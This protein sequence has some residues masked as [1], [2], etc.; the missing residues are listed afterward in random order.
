MKKLFLI[1]IFIISIISFALFYKFYR[2]NDLYLP[3]FKPVTIAIENKD[4]YK[5]IILRAGKDYY[6]FQ[7]NKYVL[8]QK[9]TTKV[10]GVD[11]YIKKGYEN[12]IKNIAIYNGIN[13]DF[14]GKI[15]E[16]E[17]TKTTICDGKN[18]EDYYIFHKKI[19]NVSSK[20]NTIC[21]FLISFISGNKIFIVPYL[22]LFIFLIF[23]KNEIFQFLSKKYTV[24]LIFI[25]AFILRLNFTTTA[26]IGDECFSISISDSTK[27]FSYLFTDAGNPPVY[28][29]LLRLL[30]TFSSNTL[31]YKLFGVLI[32]IGS[33]GAIY[34]VLKKNFNSKTANLG[35]FL[36]TINLVSI[37]FSQELRSYGLQMALTPIAVYL[38]FELLRKGKLKY[39]IYYTL[40]AII[41]INLHYFEAL[42]LFSNFFFGII[43][44]AIKNKKKDILKFLLIH[45]IIALFFMP[46]LIMTA[47]K[48]GLMNKYFNAWIDPISLKL[49]KRSACF[50][51]GSSISAIL[52]IIFS[53][54]NLFQE[55]F[56]SKTKLFNLY[57]SYL[58]F[59]VVI[60]ASL[61]S[62][63]IKP[64]ISPK[65]LCLLIPVF[66]MFLAISILKEKNKFVWCIF[67]IWLFF[68]QN[69]K[70]ITNVKRYYLNEYNM[71]KIAQKFALENKQP[72]HI[73]T[74]RSSKFYVEMKPKN[75]MK[76]IEH[77]YLEQYNFKN[78]QGFLKERT[79]ELQ[80]KDSDVLIF[81][82]LL[83]P[84][85]VNTKDETYVCY[86]NES[87]NCCV[88]KIG[89]EK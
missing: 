37:Y 49:L 44:L 71:F 70:Q 36:T 16:L 15:Q 85:S 3:K 82:T 57:F 29:M 8:S 54:K 4:G 32:S 84:D 63:F 56:L 10:D 38:L 41:L 28:F 62:Y 87:A 86:Y 60:E 61:F 22:L 43:Y 11:F 6:K 31:I 50:L 79:D 48:N 45:I 59:A 78:L 42:L 26:P 25:L 7:E 34:F 58:I 1:L 47:L 18:C 51:F 30:E 9:I 21:A 64:I 74:K 73:L 27:P 81:T 17:N 2:A 13:L 23:S 66:I 69:P 88:W 12:K 77:E 5:G 52:F 89:K 68:I 67:L 20:F 80:A 83:R 46:F 39:Y 24:F 75:S 53:I 14:Y 40:L 19:N 65:Y 72:I 55:R 76:N 35:A 33:I